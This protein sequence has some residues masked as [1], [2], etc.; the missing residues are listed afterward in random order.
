[1][2]ELLVIHTLNDNSLSTWGSTNMPPADLKNLIGWKLQ[3]EYSAHVQILGRAGRLH[4]GR[5]PWQSPKGMAG[6]GE[7]ND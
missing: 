7:E 1:M 4:G 5:D 6:F 3:Y 2:H